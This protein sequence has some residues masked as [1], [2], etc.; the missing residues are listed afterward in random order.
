MFNASKSLKATIASLVCAGIVAGAAAAAPAWQP[1]HRSDLDVTDG[2]ITQLGSDQ[3]TTDSAGMRATVLDG[4]NHA[5]RAWLMFRF[6]GKSTTTTPLGSGAIRRQIG[7]KLLATDPCNLVYVMW[8]QYPKGAIEV[9]IKRNPGQTTST[10]CGNNGYTRIA[11]ISARVNTHVRHNLRVDT[12]QT[13][14]GALKLSVYAD[15]K[16][17]RR[18][19]VP[20]SLA[21]GLDGPIGVRSDNGHY[22]FRLYAG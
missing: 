20:A 9:L 12:A 15:Y 3:L 16:L 17:I 7:L 18:L 10:Q 1:I 2:Q 14:T 8:R 5:T 19:T 4:G 13:A 21:A 6:L 11:L 22:V